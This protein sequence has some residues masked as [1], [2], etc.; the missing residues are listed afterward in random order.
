MLANMTSILILFG[1]ISFRLQTDLASL[2]NEQH[3]P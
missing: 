1:I 3:I 2:K